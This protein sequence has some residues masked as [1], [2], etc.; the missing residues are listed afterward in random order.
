MEDIIRGTDLKFNLHIEPLDGVSMEDY[1]FMVQAYCGQ[2][3]RSYTVDK[4]DCYKED[5][6]NYIVEINT[7]SLD[8]GRLIVDVT[9]YLP[10]DKMPDNIRTEVLRFDTNLNIIQ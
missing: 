8:L 6:D 5:A 1:D 7:T 10:D 9:A 2:K 3:R 4:T